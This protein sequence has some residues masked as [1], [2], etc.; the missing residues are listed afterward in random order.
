MKRRI[1]CLFLILLCVLS[2]IACTEANDNDETTT[3]KKQETTTT[4]I[5]KQERETLKDDETL[6]VNDNIQLVGSKSGKWSELFHRKNAT[7]WLNADG[8]YSCACDGDESFGSANA[9]TKSVFIFSDSHMGVTNSKGIIVTELGWVN[10]AA[11]VFTGNQPIDANAS[12]VWG[13]NGNMQYNTNLF[14]GSYWLGDMFIVR[15]T[16]Y[17]FAFDHDNAW[18][19]SSSHLVSVP[20]KNGTPDWSKASVDKSVNSTFF[21]RDSG[22]IYFYGT[23]VLVNTESANQ[24]FPDDYIY[25]YGYKEDLKNGTKSL[26]TCRIKEDVF[27]N[28]QY[29][30]YYTE[31]GVWL[32]DEIK[33]SKATL[34][35]IGCE[36]SVTPIPMGPY[37]GKYI[38]VWT[39]HS[40]SSDLVYAISDTP[41]TDWGNPVTFYTCSENGQAP[42]GGGDGYLYTYNAKAHPHLS[43]AET[44]E[45]LV[46]YN[47]NVIVNGNGGTSKDTRD[48]SCRFVW[49]DLD[50]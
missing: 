19:P 47:V 5:A 16:L 23:G 45:L 31:G 20:M 15:N 28:F 38:C 42:Y 12:Y 37:E 35:N 36:I 21:Y 10:H 34:T 29:V 4:T 46:S 8:F 30:E 18:K 27:P 33:S 40:S 24:P 2:L 41:Y 49:L 44:G 25:F 48:N 11:C 26:I 14:G 32:T 7:G 1:F 13:T 50:P 22:Y 17:I 43:N 3:T 39:K 6:K 9:T